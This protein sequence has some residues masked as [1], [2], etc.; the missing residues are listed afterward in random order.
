MAE[1]FQEKTEQPTPKRLM[2]AREKGNIPKSTEVN[3][4]LVLLAGIGLVYWGGGMIYHKLSLLS[5]NIFNGGYLAPLQPVNLKS[6]LLDGLSL[7]GWP[8]FLLMVGIMVIGLT[9]SISQVGFVFTLEPLIPK[10]EKINPLKGFKK[11]LFSSRTVEELFKNLLKLVIVISIGYLA[12][13]SY[14]HQF[15][16]LIDQSVGDIAHFMFKGAISITFKIALALVVIAGADYAFQRFEHLKNL[17]MTRQEVK[18]EHKQTEGDPKI[19]ARIRSMQMEIARRR[20]MQE[21]P[22]ADVVITNPTHYAVA[23]KY[24]PGKMASPKVVAKGKN[25]IAL[26]IKEI[27]LANGVPVMEDPPLARALY[28]VVEIDQEVPEKFF[29]AVA[30]VLAYVYKIKKKNVM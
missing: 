17:R 27:A 20:M 11:I 6:Y 29:K 24:E 10:P 3:S 16:L 5:K 25:R 1:D 23:L 19:K 7:I 12:L 2:E 9:A 22:K 13:K 28:E 4:A 18:E 21:V 26:K 30:E 8:T 15:P 14:L